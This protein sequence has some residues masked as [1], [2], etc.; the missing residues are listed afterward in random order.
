M[1]LQIIDNQTISDQNIF[2][3][4]RECAFY[5]QMECIHPDELGVNCA[6]VVF[7]N[8]FT[9]TVEID[10]PCVTFGSD[11]GCVS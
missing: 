4:C 1:E 5:M 7:C 8:S 11:W 2:Y 6:D 10:S 3:L 9:P